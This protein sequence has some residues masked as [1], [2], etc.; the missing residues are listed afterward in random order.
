MT[1]RQLDDAIDRAV[2]DMMSVDAD[3]AFRARVFDRLEHRNPTRFSWRPMLV[4]GA[5]ATVVAIVMMTMSQP[6]QP[7]VTPGSHETAAITTPP[8]IAPGP[9]LA[10]PLPAATDRTHSRASNQSTPRRGT[11]RVLVA[12]QLPRGLVVATVAPDEPAVSIEPLQAIEPIVLTPLATPRIVTED[13]LVAPLEH[14]GEV[15]IAPL[16]PRIERD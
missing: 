10:P 11:T 5:A 1:D 9:A 4:G 6:D 8:S 15:Q 7:S 16:S 14:I 3:A 13:I 2:R 12:E